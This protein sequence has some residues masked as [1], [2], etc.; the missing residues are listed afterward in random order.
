MLPYVTDPQ[1]IKEQC[2]TSVLLFFWMHKK[3]KLPIVDDFEIQYYQYFSLIQFRFLKCLIAH[4][5]IK[6]F[7]LFQKYNFLH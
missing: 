1:K 7:D 5:E 3:L 2:I 4:I 6:C